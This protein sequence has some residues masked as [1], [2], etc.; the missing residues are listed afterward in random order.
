LGQAAQ[1]QSPQFTSSTPGASPYTDYAGL[2]QQDWKNQFDSWAKEMEAKSSMGGG[3]LDL[4]GSLGGA[5]IMSDER[6]KDNIKQVG[7]TADG[8]PIYE[9]SIGDGDMQ[10]GVMAQDV[11][12]VNPAAVVEGPGGLKGVDYDAAVGDGTGSYTVEEGDSIWSIGERLGVDPQAIIEA[13]PDIQNPDF[14]VPGQQLVVPGM[15]APGPAA[16]PMSALPAAGAATG[17]PAVA[18]ALAGPAG[19]GMMPPGAMPAAPRVEPVSAPPPAAPGR[20]N[21]QQIQTI[22]EL[23]RRFPDL[24]LPSGGMGAY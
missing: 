18:A 23:K 2:I 15:A 10:T 20:F 6:I 16:I 3:I 12:A 5:A 1:V 7:K 4:A 22:M 21:P 17:I 11:E 14:I 19:P 13:N 8:L 9:F 24:Q